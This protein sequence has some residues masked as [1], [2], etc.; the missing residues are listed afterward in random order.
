MFVFVNEA[1]VFIP[2]YKYTAEQADGHPG[3]AFRLG[4]RERETFYDIPNG[5]DVRCLHDY[6]EWMAVEHK[7]LLGFVKT[8][9]IKTSGAARTGAAA[10]PKNATVNARYS[11]N[12]QVKASVGHNINFDA[13]PPAGVEVVN[14]PDKTAVFYLG[15]EHLGGFQKSR[16]GQRSKAIIEYQ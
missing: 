7:G 5:Q 9:N 12:S 15:R 11:F 6:G 14:I 8:R 2:T 4:R 1:D 13:S 10:Q 3:V 16:F